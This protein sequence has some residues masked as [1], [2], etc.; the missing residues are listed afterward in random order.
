MT[1]AELIQEIKDE[2]SN[3]CALPYNLNDQEIKRIIK[4]SRRYFYDNYQYAVEDK[5]FV[6]GKQLFSTPTFRAT[7]QVQLPEC[8]VS[9]YD[10]RQV[11]GSGLS[12]TPDKD[13]GDSKLLGSEL[14]LSPFAGDNLVYRTVLYSF[15]DLAKAY[16]LES[17]AFNYNK[18][19][20]KLTIN[21]RDP[22]RTATTNGSSGMTN[23]D[24]VD[25]GVRAY[26]AIPEESLY[27]DE[28][29]IRWCYAEAKINIGR[30]LG[31]FEYNLPGGV[32]VNYANIQS[33]GKEEKAEILAQINSE[34]TPS[35]FLQW[36]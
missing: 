19:T 6:L 13:F 28:L 17:Y 1:E 20:K 15:F 25:V 33:L 30:L 31:T 21:G 22:N 16:L 2:I 14:M 26:I 36:N 12:G 24:G 5:I 4:K 27:E 23:W 10:V 18:N 32:R 9:V 35:W 7:R 11:N 29:F 3:S 34:N 8:V